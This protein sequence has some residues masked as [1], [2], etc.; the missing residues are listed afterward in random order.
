MVDDEPPTLV[1]AWTEA[2]R[3]VQRRTH[4]TVPAQLRRSDGRRAAGAGS[5]QCVRSEAD[6]MTASLNKAPHDKRRCK[7]AAKALQ[8]RPATERRA[9]GRSL[10]QFTFVGRRVQGERALFEILVETHTK[11][12]FVGCV[13]AAWPRLEALW[14]SSS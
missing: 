9:D 14:S 10:T 13:A 6:A 1:E 11:V 3:G 4:A 12:L 7:D 5:A 8:L 2:A